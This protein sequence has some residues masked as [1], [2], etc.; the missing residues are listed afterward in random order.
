MGA[1]PSVGI[2]ADRGLRFGLA[3][4]V[5]VGLVF[6]CAGLGVSSCALSNTAYRLRSCANS[7]T[8]LCML[9]S[10]RS[11]LS[12]NCS[13]LIRCLG[14]VRLRLHR[15]IV[16]TFSLHVI[17]ARRDGL[18]RDKSTMRTASADGPSPLPLT[19]NHGGGSER[20]RTL[21]PAEADEAREQGCCA[22]PIRTEV[23]SLNP[24]RVL[25]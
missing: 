20:R 7:G 5:E 15:L 4:W 22:S 13:P 9:P 23:A 24:Y 14:A 17:E 1:A 6:R 3:V 21:P 2:G 25:T 12:R 11:V 16:L 19:K 10:P 18:R 8:R